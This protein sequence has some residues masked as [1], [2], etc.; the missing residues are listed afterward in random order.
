MIPRPNSERFDITYEETI[1]FWL[2]IVGQY[3]HRSVREK[4]ALLYNNGLVSDDNAK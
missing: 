3:S 1:A 2:I 4:S